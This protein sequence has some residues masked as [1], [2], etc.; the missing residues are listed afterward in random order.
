[1]SFG[2]QGGHVLGL[3]GRNER[4]MQRAHV[5]EEGVN[6]LVQEVVSSKASQL[7]QRAGIDGRSH[8]SAEPRQGSDDGHWCSRVGTGVSV[9]TL[10]SGC[11]HVKR[12]QEHTRLDGFEKAVIHS[13]V[14]ATPIDFAADICGQA[15]DGQASASGGVETIELCRF[16]P[17][18]DG[19]VDV[20][21]HDVE[22]AV[23]HRI[24]RLLAI[25]H[26]Q[27]RVP[28][29]LENHLKDADVD[30]IVIGNEH[31]ERTRALPDRAHSRVGRDL[32]P[33]GN[34]HRRD[35]VFV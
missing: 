6:Q 33:C 3:D 23:H 17:V 24:E 27:G 18:H 12:I 13:G 5:G 35:K 20:H 31:P 15:E 14:M 8:A 19:H 7:F 32:L 9:V 26:D 11:R 16:H 21:Q 2:A 10:A 30:R 4:R 28:G 1:M 29:P 25:G 34:P 22:P